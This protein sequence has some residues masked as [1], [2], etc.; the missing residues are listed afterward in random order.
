MTSKVTKIFERVEVH[1]TEIR[2]E[3]VPFF[4]RTSRKI[5]EFRRRIWLLETGGD[6]SSIPSFLIE[7]QYDAD[8]FHFVALDGDEIIAVSR[9]TMALS[10]DEVKSRSMF[11]EFKEVGA[12]PVA[13]IE[14]LVVD[15]K[16][17]NE[18]LGSLMEHNRVIYASLQHC[19]NV[20]VAV[21]PK[22]VGGLVRRGFSVLYETKAGFENSKLAPPTVL[23]LKI[24][25]YAQAQASRF[26]NT[27]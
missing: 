10:T 24:S 2:I 19:H 3:I 22:R 13:I 26:H 18:G 8:A 11:K 6:E 14:R 7:D 5:I 12:F 16:Y 1:R 17:R 9:M 21:P 20:L 23:F 15:P 25:E 4:G 27:G